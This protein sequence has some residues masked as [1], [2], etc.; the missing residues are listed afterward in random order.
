M[1]TKSTYML[2]A[3]IF[4]FYKKHGVFENN[5]KNGFQNKHIAVSYTCFKINIASMHHSITAKKCKFKWSFP[6]LKMNLYWK[7]HRG[8]FI[9]QM[10]AWSNCLKHRYDLEVNVEIMSTA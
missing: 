10:F 2:C 6:F 3:Q 5:S 4:K 9:L 1:I 7:L 8:E